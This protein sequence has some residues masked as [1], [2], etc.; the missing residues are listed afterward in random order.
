MRS[1]N[2]RYLSGPD[3]SA[4][5]LGNQ[6]I[7]DAVENSLKAQGNGETVIEPRMLH[8]TTRHRRCKNCR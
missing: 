1:L 6:E 4:L 5:N 8:C 3:I 7:L 2:I